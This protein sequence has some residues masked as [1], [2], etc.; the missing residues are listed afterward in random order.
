MIAVVSQLTEGLQ[1]NLFGIPIAN[2]GL[3]V[4][5]IVIL[6]IIGF[7]LFCK[8]DRLNKAQVAQ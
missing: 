3:A 7:I 8:A 2:T 6:F 5:S 1:V 4:G